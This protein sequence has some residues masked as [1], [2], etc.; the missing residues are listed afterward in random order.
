MPS[1]S[2]IVPTYNREHFLQECIESVL[3]QTFKDF[4][5]IVVDDGSTDQTEDILKQYEGKLHYKKQEQK[6]PSSARNTGIQYSAGEW[7]CFLDSDDLWLPGKLAAQM[8]FFAETRDIKVCYTEEIWYRKNNRVNPAKKHQKYSGWI[9]QKMLPLCIISPSSVMIHHS[10]LDLIGTFDE[11]LPACEDYDLWLRIGAGY[12]IYLLQEQLIIKR[13][14]HSGQQSQKY[15]GMDRFRIL[16][17]VKIMECG[18]LSKE[19]Y[20]A[21]VKILEEKCRILANGSKKRGKV[22]EAN[23][24]IALAQK[25]TSGTGETLSI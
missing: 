6:G 20:Q 11:E 9:Y 8:K 13:N 18:E 5:L 21:T 4:E 1:V 22:R 19:N 14:G 23:D 3:S 15:W 10:V 16:S 25:Y 2:V 7:I 12:P 17:L 24:Y